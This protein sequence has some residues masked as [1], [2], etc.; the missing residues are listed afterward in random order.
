MSD[1]PAIE[2]SPDWLSAGAQPLNIGAPWRN[3]EGSATHQGREGL[4][5]DRPL[6][7][8]ESSTTPPLDLGPFEMDPV[9]TA[10]VSVAAGANVSASTQERPGDLLPWGQT[11]AEQTYSQGAEQSLDPFAWLCKKPSSPLS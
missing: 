10:D 2:V 9:I 7:T 11:G 6:A 5:G 1:L 8:P 3:H 4:S